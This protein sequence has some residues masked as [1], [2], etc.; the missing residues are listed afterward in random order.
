ML[1]EIQNLFHP[2]LHLV[3]STIQESLCRKTVTKRDFAVGMAQ[4]CM[5]PRAPPSWKLEA[6]PLDKAQYQYCSAE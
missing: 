4:K 6:M 2:Y 5:P 3:M 1:L